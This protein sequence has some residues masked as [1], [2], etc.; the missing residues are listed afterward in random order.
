M[1]E[2]QTRATP[3]QPDTQPADVRR[4]LR[5]DNI[6]KQGDARTAA[7]AGAEPDS[8]FGAVEDPSTGHSDQVTVTPP[9]A[10]GPYNVTRGE[11][12][13]DEDVDP[14]TEISGG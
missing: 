9:M 12:K 14:H 7:D 13:Q 2:D 1:Q 11:N 6:D 3:E 10:Q 8:H 4:E 5:Q